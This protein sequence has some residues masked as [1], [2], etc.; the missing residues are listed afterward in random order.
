MTAT[1]SDTPIAPERIYLQDEGVALPD[2]DG[3]TWCVDRIND[4]DTE[5]VRKDIHERQLTETRRLLVEARDCIELSWN[6]GLRQS[7]M[8]ELFTRIDAAI[9]EQP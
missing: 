1:K 5:Y 6:G 9:K 4:N 8:E 2:Y 3:V 7:K